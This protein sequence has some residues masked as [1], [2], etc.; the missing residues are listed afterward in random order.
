LRDCE[1]RRKTPGIS[2]VGRFASYAR[3]N[4]DWPAPPFPVGIID[5]CGGV[6]HECPSQNSTSTKGSGVGT[7]LRFR[8]MNVDSEATLECRRLRTTAEEAPKD[9]DLHRLAS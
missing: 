4:G 9:P 6:E 2:A 5:Q 1:S 3:V 8:K 7:A